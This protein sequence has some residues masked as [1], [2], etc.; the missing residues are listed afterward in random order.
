MH[1]E[2]WYLN[3]VTLPIPANGDDIWYNMS[4]SQISSLEGS[5]ARRVEA[6]MRRQG[7]IGTVTVVASIHSTP[8]QVTARAM[9]SQNPK[10]TNQF[11]RTVRQYVLDVL[12]YIL[13]DL[14]AQK[15][16]QN[17]A[18]TVHSQAR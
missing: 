16:A 8:R 10:T 11:E 12:T 7:D 9:M 2:V 14:R 17:A 1:N 13:T 18:P 15:G 5:T 6:V 4:P 3:E